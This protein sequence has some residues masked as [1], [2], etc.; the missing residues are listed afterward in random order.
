MHATMR[1]KLL[2][3]GRE[4]PGG[5]TNTQRKEKILEQLAQML[6]DYLNSGERE[7]PLQTLKCPAFV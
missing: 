5:P 3:Q 6:R 4:P 1:A 7:E 2:V